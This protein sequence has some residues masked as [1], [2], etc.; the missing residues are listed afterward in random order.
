MVR[1]PPRGDL[2]KLLKTTLIV[3]AVAAFGGAALSAR[4]VRLPRAEKRA[5]GALGIGNS[6]RNAAVLRA[7]GLA[8]GDTASGRVDIS[9][10][11][12]AGDMFLRR[13]ALHDSNQRRPLS[14]RLTLVV[15]EC[16]MF[17]SGRPPRCE[18]GDRIVYAGSLAYMAAPVSLGRFDG[19]ER[20]RYAFR[21]VFRPSAGNAYMGAAT[22][23]SFVWSVRK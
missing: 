23:A 20:R 2:T 13:G 21:A 5:D 9:S 16:G 3:T 7:S 12:A 6:R 14:E 1:V 18:R 15:R 10:A 17:V 8:P 22:Q 4:L 11:G 19:G